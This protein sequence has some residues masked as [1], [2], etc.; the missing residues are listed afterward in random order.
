MT[1]PDRKP[2]IIIQSTHFT[3]CGDCSSAQ[4]WAKE[5]GSGEDVITVRASCTIVRGGVARAKIRGEV[6][7]PHGEG[8]TEEIKTEEIYCP[9]IAEERLASG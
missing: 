9:G 6:V 2:A 3:R 8:T 7:V 5:A 1:T 4:T